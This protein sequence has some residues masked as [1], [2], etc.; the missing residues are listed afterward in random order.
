MSSLWRFILELLVL[1]T[2]ASIITWAVTGRPKDKAAIAQLL[3]DARKKAAEGEVAEATVGAAVE[4]A[5]VGT[6]QAYVTA[7]GAAFQEER[8]SLTRRLDKTSEQQTE[9]R[10]RLDRV[11]VQLTEAYEL[12]T[13]LREDQRRCHREMLD[14]YRR[15]A[16]HAHA[17]QA[18]ADWLTDSLPGLRRLDPELPPP[19]PLEPLPPL[20]PWPDDG[21][22]PHRR[23]YDSRGPGEEGGGGMTPPRP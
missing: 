23:W 21:R 1:P 3:E 4:L 7:M 15:D 17:L 10:E 20:L 2:A 5:D 11:R 8:E 6:L 19:P 18:L 12:I 9:T 13:D 16:Y 22:E 14:M